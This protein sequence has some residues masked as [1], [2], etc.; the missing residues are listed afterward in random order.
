MDTMEATN[1][2]TTKKKKKTFVEKLQQAKVQKYLKDMRSSKKRAFEL[3]NFNQPRVAGP[4]TPP[5]DP[6]ACIEAAVG[7][8]DDLQDLL[9]N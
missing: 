6:K 5:I 9:D 2:K 7:M 8:I 3:P 4:A 1:V